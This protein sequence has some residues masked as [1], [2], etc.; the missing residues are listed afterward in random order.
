M[1]PGPPAR[2]G[3][4]SA[5][6]ARRAARPAG[7]LSPGIRARGWR[8]GGVRGGVERRGEGGSGD[9]VAEEG[10]DVALLR[11]AEAV[12]QA[13]VGLE[14][15]PHA[16]LRQPAVALLPPRVLDDEVGVAVTHEDRGIRGVE[17]AGAEGQPGAQ[18]QEPPQ[19]PVRHRRRCQS[20][21]AA[22]GE[23][24]QHHP[25]RVDARRHLLVH[26]L[27]EVRGALPDAALVLRGVLR[28]QREDVE[29]GRHLHPAVEGDAERGR[30]REEELDVRHVERA[31]H[32]D[33]AEPRV[34]QPVQPDDGRRVL[35]RRRRRHALGDRAVDAL[36][37]RAARRR[38][39]LGSLER[40]ERPG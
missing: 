5:Q 29:P 28:V 26:Q 21:S 40:S 12:V 32:G 37:P 11:I 22:L 4:R 15:G 36:G 18:P 6:T 19:R 24:G 7:G 31:G 13:P 33:P 20:H 39:Q 25:A 2:A 17:G 23:A 10:G 3:S 34:P 14:L 16:E 30:R 1:S 27:H 9:A 35:P 8:G 38:R